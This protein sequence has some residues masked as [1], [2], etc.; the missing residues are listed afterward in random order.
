MWWPLSGDVGFGEFRR[1]LSYKATWYGSRIVVVSRW[2]P[3][4]KICSVC[5]VVKAELALSERVY[6]CDMCG[7]A[8]DRD[9]NAALN[10]RNVAKL[11]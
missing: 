5:G 8:L 1:Q 6:R 9:L 4:S 3:S 10:L 7:L 2:E 11:A